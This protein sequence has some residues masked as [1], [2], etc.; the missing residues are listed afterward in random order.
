MSRARSRVAAGRHA[1]AR[2]EAWVLSRDMVDYNRWWMH[3]QSF[4][5]GRI[6]SSTNEVFSRSFP[7]LRGLGQLDSSVQIS[8]ELI[9]VCFLFLHPS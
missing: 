2:D 3:P 5:S 9:Q 8:H 6:S 4:L 1:P 7:K